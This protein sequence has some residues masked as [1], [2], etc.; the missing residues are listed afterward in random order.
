M[1]DNY[2]NFEH[3]DYYVTI[4]SVTFRLCVVY[5]PPPSK[6]NGFSNTVF[7]DQWSAFLDDRM[8]DMHDV[9]I[10]GDLNF[11]LDIPI[12]LDVRRFSATL[13]DRGMKQLVNKA[14][15][16]KGHILDVVIVRDNTFIVP[17]LP[18]VYDPCLCDTHGN[19][20]GD[21]LAICFGVN[22]RKPS[23]VRKTTTFRR[24]RQI[25]VSDIMTDTASVSV[26][27]VDGP[28]GAMVEAYDTGLHRI[29]DHHAPL[30]VKTVTLRPN[31]TWYTDELRREKHNRRR[32][33]RTWLRTGLV[34]HRL[35]Y[36]AQCVVVN[37]MLLGAKRNYYT[38]KIASCGSSQKQLFNITKS[39]MGVS[40]HAQ[41]PSY[42]S[43][44][45]LA[46]RLSSHFEKKVSDIRQSRAHRSGD[47]SYAIAAAFSDDTAFRCAVL[48]WQASQELMIQTFQT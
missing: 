48:S 35:V 34:I 17:A 39:L 30:V 47:R 44:N 42:V 40:C 23:G 27:L 21:H 22:A 36:R 37:R 32:A 45:D 3:S 1:R 15:H 24:L 8:L 13:C 2:T 12:Q 26:L 38:D 7:L 25:S 9:I 19:S 5:R 29:V 28:D 31:S 11:H 41:L 20:S 16:S 33:E 14:T 6:R 46:Q 18:N 43:S 10:T 4:R